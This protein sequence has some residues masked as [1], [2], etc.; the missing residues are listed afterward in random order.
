MF[1]EILPKFDLSYCVHKNRKVCEMEILL[2][3]YV[4]VDSMNENHLGRWWHVLDGRIIVRTKFTW[5]NNNRS[6]KLSTLVRSIRDVE[7][8]GV[9]CRRVP[10]SFDPT[11]TFL[12]SFVSLF[13]S[14]K[15]RSITAWTNSGY[16]IHSFIYDQTEKTTF[17]LWFYL[18]DLAWFSSRKLERKPPGLIVFLEEASMIKWIIKEKFCCCWFP[19][20]FSF[21]VI[22]VK[23]KVKKSIP[24][25]EWPIF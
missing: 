15:N 4:G 16:S 21:I 24:R 12:H 13:V 5:R 3:A 2:N 8:E 18:Y 1:V 22:W 25:S 9:R 23:Q 10:K 14:A 11:E 17:C 6:E 19:S 7:T 20:R